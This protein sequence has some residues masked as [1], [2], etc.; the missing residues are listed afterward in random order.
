MNRL[1]SCL[2]ATALMTAFAAVSAQNAVVD[3]KAGAGG[4]AESV[5]QDSRSDD[6]V[7]APRAPS[8]AQGGAVENRSDQGAWAPSEQGTMR[9]GPANPS[10]LKKPD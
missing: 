8:T 2:T 5:R 1:I 3:L 9:G 10:G 4:A 6:S 7:R